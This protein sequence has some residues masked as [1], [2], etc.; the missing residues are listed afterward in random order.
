MKKN[1]VLFLLSIGVL[2][3]VLFIFAMSMKNTSN[4]T[5]HVV[6]ITPFMQKTLSLSHDTI[7]DIGTHRVEILLGHVR[8]T[9]ATCA[10]KQC[11][12]TGWVGDGLIICAPNKVI[13]RVTPPKK[14]VFTDAITQ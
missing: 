12:K 7:I 8:V 11:E 13:I 2:I 5:D 14:N 9:H 1:D 6:I 4:D 3:S 10:G